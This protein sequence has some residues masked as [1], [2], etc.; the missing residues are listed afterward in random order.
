MELRDPLDNVS[1]VPIFT[2]CWSPQVSELMKED[3]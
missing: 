3:G 2:N 1:N